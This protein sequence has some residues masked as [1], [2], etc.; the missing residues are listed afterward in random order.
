MH[1]N[2]GTW[3]RDALDRILLDASLIQDP[4]LRVEYIAQ[5]FL[6]VPYKESSLIGDA[7]TEEE[8]VID[9]AGVDC[10]TFIDYIEAMRVSDSFEAFPERLTRVRYRSDQISFTTRNH[11]FSD[12]S[13][14]N[15]DFIEEVTEYIGKQHAGSV[16]K[17]L[18]DKEDGTC[19]IPGT[20]L[21]ERNI[22]YIPGSDI[23][24]SIMN[25]LK[26]G[27]YIGVYSELPGLDVSHVGIIV[28]HD[29]S[30]ILRH[31]SSDNDYRSVV[32]QDF[33]QYIKDRPGLIVL[34]PR[35]K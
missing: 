19:W 32:D 23:D 26:T 9:L 30:V 27:D 3:S 22:L 13:A 1:I 20:P 14:Y 6:G 33:E 16:R 34:R 10:F 4:G 31:A 29:E 21:I 2:L 28:R 7:H 5:Q 18:N 8:L 25:R 17:M 12:W 35:K 24:D 15:T 11:F